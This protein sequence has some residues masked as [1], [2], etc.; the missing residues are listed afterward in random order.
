[1]R[2]SWADRAWTAAHPEFEA[3]LDELA[4]PGHRAAL[5][6]NV[7]STPCA[8]LARAPGGDYLSLL[9]V[10]ARRAGLPPAAATVRAAGGIAERLAVIPQS[11]MASWTVEAGRVDGEPVAVHQP[12]AG[13]I[14]RRQPGGRARRPRNACKPGDAQGDLRLPRGMAAPVPVDLRL[15]APSGLS[16]VLAADRRQ[17]TTPAWR[18]HGAGRGGRIV[19]YR[20]GRGLVWRW[21]AM[22]GPYPPAAGAPPRAGAAL[23][24]AGGAVPGRGGR[25][26]IAG[27]VRERPTSAAGRLS[28]RGRGRRAARSRAG[29]HD[30]QSDNGDGGAAA[31]WAGAARYG[32]AAGGGGST[33]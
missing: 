19:H 31:T 33:P 3:M 14:L 11:R 21:D 27:A 20:I 12:D 6:A 13:S 7:E 32:G 17:W 4:A 10:A 24:R 5:K 23:M 22:R 18:S 16:G 15:A 2:L 25:S 9:A 28:S 26:S 1:M 29:F 8:C 30:P